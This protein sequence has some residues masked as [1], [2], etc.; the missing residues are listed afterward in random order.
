MD[1]TII[2]GYIW[3]DK[4]EDRIMNDGV[5]S[6]LGGLTVNVELTTSVDGE[7]K[8]VESFSVT[9]GRDG[10]YK[11][12][13]DRSFQVTHTA[14]ITIVPPNRRYHVQTAPLASY[15]VADLTK[16]TFNKNTKSITLS[17]NY[18]DA[19]TMASCGMVVK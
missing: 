17:S 8:T 9:T 10:F 19:I 5:D 14:N 2:A 11:I 7:T 1:R 4:N 15:H 13:F 6:Y 16:H 3:N 18:G 12:T